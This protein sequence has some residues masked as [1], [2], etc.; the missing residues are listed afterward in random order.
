[1]GTDPNI[2]PHWAAETKE[3]ALRLDQYDYYE[4]LG[5]PYDA[6][7]T[8]IKSRY[9]AL[10]RT[11]HPDTFFQS[12]DDELKQAVF[13]IAKRVAEA[14]VFLRDDEK[15]KKYT[16]EVTGPDRLRKLRFTDEAEQEVR[17]EKIEAQGKTPQG[18]ELVKKA[19]ANLKRGDLGAAQRDFQT[20]LVFEPTN[21]TIKAHLAD[22]KA[23]LDDK[24]KT[25][26]KP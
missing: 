5:C 20:A 26:K 1:V 24:K 12:P 4:V 7:L 11:Y 23:Q 19:L 3:L 14:Y 6:D 13:R 17:R 21:E 22:V 9:H 10:Q 15:R 25:K 8:T 16:T 2:H 18:R